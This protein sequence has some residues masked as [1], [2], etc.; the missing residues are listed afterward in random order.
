MLLSSF[1]FGKGTSL[2]NRVVKLIWS[3]IISLQ[4]HAIQTYCY[5]ERT[6]AFVSRHR[7]KN[8]KPNLSC[9]SQ[10][11]HTKQRITNW[12]C[13][14][15]AESGVWISVKGGG[16]WFAN[17]QGRKKVWWWLLCEF[18]LAPPSLNSSSLTNFHH[19]YSTP[20]PHPPTPFCV[21]EWNL[22][23]EEKK[24][25]KK[26]WDWSFEDQNEYVCWELPCKEKEC[27][28]Y[29]IKDKAKDEEET[30]FCL[31]KKVENIYIPNN[32]QTHVPSIIVFT[33]I[34]GSLHLCWGSKQCTL[35]PSKQIKHE[36]YGNPL[37]H[38]N[39]NN[40]NNNNRKNAWLTIIN[41]LWENI[42]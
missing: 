25:K 3:C 10:C 41:Q 38:H 31:Q 27:I 4:S 15:R 21:L 18:L 13:Q 24:K 35:L 40:N 32:N 39:H 6:T 22:G 28:W 11:T 37:H 16:D 26:G 14:L 12:M 5:Y 8:K 7:S 20:T 34:Y 42:P 36:G 1:C 17:H 9:Q 2:L 19:F 23:E 29:D 30:K 33:W